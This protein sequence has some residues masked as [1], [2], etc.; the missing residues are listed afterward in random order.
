LILPQSCFLMCIIAY[1]DVNE[2]ALR[3]LGIKKA[4]QDN[5]PA[6]LFN[7][8]HRGSFVIETGV[9]K[10]NPFRIDVYT[11]LFFAF[12]GVVWGNEL[13]WRVAFEH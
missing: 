5:T 7:F 10:L 9:T 8:N 2:F 12:R 13:F 6:G 4:P 1:K 3:V 11:L